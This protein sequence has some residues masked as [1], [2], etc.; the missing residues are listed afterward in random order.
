ML[1]VQYQCNSQSASY[2]H[3][4]VIVPRCHTYP[5]DTYR[6]MSNEC[7]TS[8]DLFFNLVIFCHSENCIIHC[9]TI[10][11]FSQEE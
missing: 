3:R 5:S 4:G 8:I 2:S 7:G 9:L 11:L 10:Q 6:D 1:E